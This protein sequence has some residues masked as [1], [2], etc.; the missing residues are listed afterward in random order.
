MNSPSLS[1]IT[2]ATTVVGQTPAADSA[3]A[4]R[5]GSGAGND[6]QLIASNQQADYGHDHATP[7]SSSLRGKIRQ[8]L[9]NLNPRHL[10]SSF[11]GKIGALAQSLMKL[12][13]GTRPQASASAPSNPSPYD[14]IATRINSAG[15]GLADEGQLNLNLIA[16]F[17]RASQNIGQITQQLSQASRAQ[18]ADNPQQLAEPLQ[19]TI[20]SAAALQHLQTESIND[21]L[22]A[23]P[24][25]GK[26]PGAD[27][28]AAGLKRAKLSLNV[29][30]AASRLATVLDLPYLPPNPQLAKIAEQL[31]GGAIRVGQFASIDN[32]P[33]QQLAQSEHFGA[34]DDAHLRSWLN[35]ALA[36]VGKCAQTI[37]AAML[38]NDT[39]FQ[40]TD[41]DVNNLRQL[42]QAPLPAQETA[43]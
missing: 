20:G 13:T 43:V 33:Y 1:P 14:S 39:R 27:A 19:K 38:A 12:F 11:A 25:F 42:G 24:Q 23:D 37:D 15:G 5:V 28:Q 32:N 22:A 10:G 21:I 16:D 8:A 36:V 26:L 35:Q 41:I 30:G 9:A 4:E 3:G 18:L 34:A 31:P 7:S 2:P 6:V 17:H 29:T 40:V